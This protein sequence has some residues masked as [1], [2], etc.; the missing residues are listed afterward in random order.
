MIVPPLAPSA[1]VL[2]VAE[3]HP[4]RAQPNVPG[5]NPSLEISRW[6]QCGTDNIDKPQERFQGG[7]VTKPKTKATAQSLTRLERTLK[8]RY[9]GIGFLWAWVYGS[10]ETFAVFPERAGIGINAD[11]SWLA[12]AVVVT[13]TL[14]VLGF[15]LGRRQTMAPPWLTVA[16]GVATA[17]GTLLWRPPRGFLRQQWSAARLRGSARALFTYC[18]D[19]PWQ[20]WTSKAPKSPSRLL[21]LSCSAA[22]WFSPTCQAPSASW[23]PPLCLSRRALCCWP[24]IE[25]FHQLKTQASQQTAC[26]GRRSLPSPAS[27]RCF[28]SHI[29]S[30]DALARCKRTPT[31]PSLI[32]AS[33]SPPSSAQSAASPS[34]SASY[35]SPHVQVST[36]SFGSLP[37]SLPSPLP[38]CRGQICGPLLS[39]RALLPLRTPRLPSPQCFSW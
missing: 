38:S 4:L 23:R 21:P 31:R 35:C 9:L 14:F 3:A 34:W 33:T 30:S 27:P 1:V 12:S 18:G 24:P 26:A 16:A 22:L 7:N 11:S 36:D 2:F 37:R 17:A 32:G 20:R 5:R 10:F 25:I 8:V 19:R 6:T 29:S 39:P 28:S 15:V 13:L